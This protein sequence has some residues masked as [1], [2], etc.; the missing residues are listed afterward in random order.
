[1][2]LIDT[3]L[4]VWKSD[5]TDFTKGQKEVDKGVDDTIDKLGKQDQ[6]LKATG[7]N[8]LALAGKVAGLV[9]A[10]A[11][12]Q[13]VKSIAMEAAEQ[14]NALAEQ[15][16]SLKVNADE[17][18]TWQGAIV[19]AGGSVE[20]LSA[21]IKSLSERTKDPLAELEK[22][23][24]RFK[25]LTDTQADKLGR[26]LGIDESLVRVM[27]QGTSALQDRLK[28]QMQ[29]GSVTQE[30]IDLANKYKLV[31]ADTNT[32]YDDVRR[33]I[34]VWVLPSM[35]E[36][37]KTMQR[38]VMWLR[39]NSTFVFT[40]FGTMATL[41]MARVLPAIIAMGVQWL[42][43]SA[44]FLASPLGIAIA[45]VVALSA[46]I[47]LVVDDIMAFEE[48]GKSLIGD[49]AAR[50]PIIGVI[51]H[52]I[53]DALKMLW[54][55][56]RAVFQYLKDVIYEPGKAL[57]NLKARLDVVFNAMTERFPIMG[58]LVKGFAGIISSFVGGA[59]EIFEKLFDVVGK[60][61]RLLAD[62][63]IGKAVG[64][65]VDKV[66]SAA[67]TTQDPNTMARYTLPTDKEIEKQR[68]AVAAG[69]SAVSAAQGNPL[70]STTSN[71]ITNSAI[72]NKTSTKTVT[73]TG[74]I[75]IEAKGADAATVQKSVGA[76][77]GNEIKKAMDNIDDG[78]A[79]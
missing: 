49:I 24:D 20:G 55:I 44:L 77:L 47:A 16:K 52:D 59:I 60:V 32:L 7:E 25:G 46:A 14:T 38:I 29:L 78:V 35:I 48:G 18:R 74:P 30:Q 17:L 39:D 45:A 28:W 63:P 13:A 68:A 15:A 2:N 73:M 3:F 57:D 11:S 12:W 4:Y 5:T 37:E 54:E 72:T 34:M 66:K 61:W 64:A 26:S 23:A 62:S 58:G 56:G 51:V 43:T 53:V 9:A 22:V 1:M 27:Q 19:A 50:W 67:E 69:K 42:R 6:A 71:A 41:I 31:L 76:G 75:T 21:T 40:F 10:Y 79:I 65:V 8:F 33:R 70:N 36:W